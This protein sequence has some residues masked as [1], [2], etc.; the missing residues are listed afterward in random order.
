MLTVYT[1]PVVIVYVLSLSS[2]VVVV[3]AVNL[4]SVPVSASATRRHTLKLF[5]DYSM[6]T[7]FTLHYI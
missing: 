4:T 5:Y 1:G 3:V 6:T 7:V 2:V